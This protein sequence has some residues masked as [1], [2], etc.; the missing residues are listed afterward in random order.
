MDLIRK[1]EFT[2]GQKIFF[3]MLFFILDKKVIT[4]LKWCKP[5]MAWKND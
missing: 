5:E 3:N 4:A 1:S 2:P